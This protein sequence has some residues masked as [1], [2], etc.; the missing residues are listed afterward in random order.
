MTPPLASEHQLRVSVLLLSLCF[1]RV[2]LAC[3]ELISFWRQVLK[4][5]DDLQLL[6]HSD[7]LL[8][9]LLVTWSGPKSTKKGSLMDGICPCQN[10]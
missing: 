10:P 9:G 1:Q 7:I 4:S 3:L 6:K 2:S 5:V 8:V